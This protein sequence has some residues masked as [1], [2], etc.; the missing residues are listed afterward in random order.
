LPSA[1]PDSVSSDSCKAP[2]EKLSP[3][4]EMECPYEAV[5]I[6]KSRVPATLETEPRP[7]PKKGAVVTSKPQDASGR[8]DG[9]N[10][11]STARGSGRAAALPATTGP[12]SKSDDVKDDVGAK[13]P[14]GLELSIGGVGLRVTCGVDG[15]EA[16]K[17][18][19]RGRGGG[20]ARGRGT[21]SRSHLRVF[22]LTR[23]YST[24]FQ[25]RNCDRYI[26]IRNNVVP[27][28]K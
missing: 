1:E 19:A 14:P 16:T 12:L 15:G 8:R 9:R 11:S 7:Q 18:V 3:F 28:E 6:T 27:I 24:N 25:A 10:S 21:H 23:L 5:V 2:S 22:N 20:R 4:V 17:G 26:G 13:N